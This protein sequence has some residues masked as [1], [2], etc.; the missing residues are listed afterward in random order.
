MMRIANLIFL[1][2]FLVCVALQHNDPDPLPW[3]AMYGVAAVACTAW[4]LRFRRV[5]AV[6]ALVALTALAW[7]LTLAPALL[8]VAPGELVESMQ[9]KGGL[10][11]EARE[12]GGLLIVFAWMVALA[13][14]GPPRDP[15][16][17]QPL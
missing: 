6:A 2:L 7:G 5:R 16:A 11:E 12:A 17:N 3:M 4:A 14:A 1:G 13:I 9:A 10:V 8:K 15:N